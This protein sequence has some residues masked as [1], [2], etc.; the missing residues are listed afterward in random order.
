MKPSWKFWLTLAVAALGILFV[1][2]AR[3]NATASPLNQNAF[4]LDVSE[5]VSAVLSVAVRDLV[6]IR[7]EPYLAREVNPIQ[8]LGDG[9]GE[10]GPSIG[11]DALVPNSVN[12]GT[13]PDPLVTFEGVPSLSGVTPP[14]TNGDVGPSNYIQMTNFH[15]QIWD[16]GDP[17]N[18]I[19]P[20]PLTAPIA[21]GTFFT[22]LGAVVRAALATRSWCMTIWQTVGC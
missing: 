17:N 22:P 20:T 3:V 6:P 4:T 15:F 9:V 8:W 12:G 10:A 2:D 7:A 14:D 5:P 19:P 16:K 13:S 1:L 21:L 11:L 18:A